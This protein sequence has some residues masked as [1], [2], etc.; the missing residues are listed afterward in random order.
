VNQVVIMTKATTPAI[1]QFRAKLGT[2]LWRDLDIEGSDTLE[3]LS[4][5][6]LAAYNFQCDHCYGFYSKLKGN[7]SKS[8]E[9]YELFADQE[10]GSPNENAK[11]VQETIIDE[12]FSPKKTDRRG[13]LSPCTRQQPRPSRAATNRSEKIIVGRTS[14]SR[15]AIARPALCRASCYCVGAVFLV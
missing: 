10:E 7:K 8:D 11:G 9:V 13:T 6:I 1:F 3:T 15:H 5:A 14:R 12:V 2:G 4:A